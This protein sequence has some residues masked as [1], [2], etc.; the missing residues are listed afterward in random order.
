MR[1]AGQRMSIDRLS[2]VGY[3][4]EKKKKQDTTFAWF[5]VNDYLDNRAQPRPIDRREKGY[6]FDQCLAD[7]SQIKPK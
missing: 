3:I 2:A 7:I 1:G 6:N 5:Q 4:A